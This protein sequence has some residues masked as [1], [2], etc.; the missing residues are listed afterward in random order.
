[1]GTITVRQISNHLHRRALEPHDRDLAALVDLPDAGASFEGLVT[2]RLSIA[3]QRRQAA[4]RHRRLDSED[5]VLLSLWW[6]E[7]A[8]RLTRTELAAAVGVSVAHAGVR[9]QRM[10][11]QLE[12][13][14]ALVAAL[15]ARPR[16]AELDLLVAGW[17]GVPTST[18]RKRLARHVRGCAVCDPAAGELLAAE[19]LLFGLALLPVPAALT[20]AVIGKG[21]LATAT[22]SAAMAG[23]AK[24]GVIGHL[25]KVFAAPP[26][27]AMVVTGTVVV[28]AA[29]AVITWPAEAPLPPPA[30]VAPPSPT[31]VP[32]PSPAVRLPS[33][34]ARWRPCSRSRRP[35]SPGCR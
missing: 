25:A 9:V 28:G 2:L 26:I 34:A 19:K 23:V 13:C 14:R 21:A 3:D 24:I 32:A 35:A 4:R 15:D 22:S 1:M 6:L 12:Q 30:A 8:G 20:A 7:L 27:A 10:R 17:D 16:C 33:P 31:V 18:M 11:Q 29:V 5:R